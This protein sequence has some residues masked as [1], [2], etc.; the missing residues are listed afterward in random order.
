M[1]QEIIHVGLTLT[2]LDR[3]V[4]F[5]RDVLGLEY[6]GEMEMDGPKTEALFQKPGCRACVAYLNGSREL[7]APPVELIQFVGQIVER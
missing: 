3:S 7:A 1:L 2:D 6:L 5:Y 4:S